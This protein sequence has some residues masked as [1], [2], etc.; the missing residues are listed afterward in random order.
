MNTTAQEWRDFLKKPG[1]HGPCMRPEWLVEGCPKCDHPARRWSI[2]ND[3]WAYCEAC[4]WGT[5]H[6][7]SYLTRFMAN[8]SPDPIHG[9]KVEEVDP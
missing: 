3:G 5:A 9:Y 4:S 6:D 7:F 2:T 1:A 8:L